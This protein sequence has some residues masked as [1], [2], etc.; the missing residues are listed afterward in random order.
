MLIFKKMAR[1][2]IK[3]HNSVMKQFVL[4][5]VLSGILFFSCG[6]SVNVEQEAVPG[7]ATGDVVITY[8]NGYF[9]GG[10]FIAVG[11]YIYF[12]Q[13]R[14]GESIPDGY[15]HLVYLKA[16]G[17]TRNSGQTDAYTWKVTGLPSW[18]QLK[19]TGSYYA[20]TL[21]DDPN[22][23]G[24]QLYPTNYTAGQLID[25][26][27]DNPGSGYNGASAELQYRGV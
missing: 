12:F 6:K 1:N 27:I 7:L 20:L 15:S 16:T 4:V 24:N 9:T 26:V 22:S 19:K 10:S 14:S 23:P 21:A 8:S 5:A 3:I 13:Q 17:G 11:K 25:I 2:P 18:L